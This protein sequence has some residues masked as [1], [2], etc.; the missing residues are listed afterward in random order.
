MKSTTIT[1]ALAC[2]S[3]LA[4]GCGMKVS[5]WSTTSGGKKKQ[6]N[7][8]QQAANGQPA[9]SGTA[10]GAT[11]SDGAAGRGDDGETGGEA[12]T[13]DT[14]VPPRVTLGEGFGPNPKA[15]YD[16]RTPIPTIKPSDLGAAGNDCTSIGKTTPNPAIVFELTED[17]DG[18]FAVSASGG[19]EAMVLFTPGDK[20]WCGRLKTTVSFGEWR[21]GEYQLYLTK[22]VYVPDED[23]LGHY[24]IEFEDTDRD[25]VYEAGIETRELGSLGEVLV[26]DGAVRTDTG[27][28]DSRRRGEYDCN[29]V[30]FSEQPNY[31]IHTTRPLKDVE[32]YLAW[33]STDLVLRVHGPLHA[34]GSRQTRQGHCEKDNRLSYNKL[35]GTYAVYVGAPKGSSAVDFSLLVRN[36]KTEIDRLYQAPSIP[37]GLA[38]ADRS[39]I[40]HYPYLD[41]MDDM[42][43][44][45]HRG[46]ETRMGLFR[47]A[48]VDLFVYPQFDL[49]DASAET[50]KG[51]TLPVKNEPLL[52]VDVHS[53]GKLQVL[54]A[55]GELFWTWDKYLATAP[56]GVAAVP[57]A[58]RQ[59]D[60]DLRT[61]LEHASPADAKDVKAYNKKKDKF[62]KCYYKVMERYENKVQI[63]RR[64]DTYEV[65]DLEEKG[66][67]VARKK[68][69]ES[70]LDKAAKKLHA[71]LLKSRTK[72]RTDAL[73]ATRKRFSAVAAK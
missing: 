38:I 3:L 72:R 73:E 45:K 52:V 67:R 27:P 33:S 31:F 28:P 24:T 64:G 70:K 4:A 12:P 21:A 13:A 51:L 26:L 68:C 36:G 69:G 71:K 9:A 50:R 47:T 40:N 7:S 35:E 61:S 22:R 57:E 30:Q 48:P 29:S 23:D 41:T 55:D 20:V 53:K 6:N 39:I 19:F 32:L 56:D 49:D 11:T 16:V 58:L 46:D 14:H 66:D 37:S 63:K 44:R 25:Q 1:A 2:A 42:Y 60:M 59:T 17:M 15:V 8:A 62:D 10:D 5:T 18:S 43:R 34:D 54:T 65:S